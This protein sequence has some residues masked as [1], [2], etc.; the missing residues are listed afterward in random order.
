VVASKV[1]KIDADFDRRDE[2]N[3]TC[4]ALEAADGKVEEE[5]L[6]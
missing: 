4:C 3:E 1:T 5:S 6:M 2:K